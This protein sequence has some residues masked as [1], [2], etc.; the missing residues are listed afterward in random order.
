VANCDYCGKD[1]SIEAIRCPNCG[2][3]GKTLTLKERQT[4][5]S[6][7]FWKELALSCLA[8]GAV[9]LLGIIIIAVSDIPNGLASFWINYSLG[10]A[11]IFIYIKMR[12]PR[13]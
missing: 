12:K 4:E 3:T 13:K 11:P 9:W 6:N 5:W 7:D 10:F 2:E 8:A 1:I